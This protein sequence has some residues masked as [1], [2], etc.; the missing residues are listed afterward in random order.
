MKL[1]FVQKLLPAEADSS[2]ITQERAIWKT[3][4]F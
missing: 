3:E 1:H 2:K 4:K